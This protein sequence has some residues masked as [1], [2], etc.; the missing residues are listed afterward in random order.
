[1][2]LWPIYVNWLR[3][4]MAKWW[5]CEGINIGTNWFGIGDTI[6]D[7]R[8]LDEIWCLLGH[9]MEFWGAAE[10]CEDNTSIM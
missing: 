4:G 8:I 6:S 7:F 3:Y 1:M 10:C 9:A 2:V 5:R